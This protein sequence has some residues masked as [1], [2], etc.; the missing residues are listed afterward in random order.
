MR[1]MADRLGSGARAPSEK[2]EYH[3]RPCDLVK[4]PSPWAWLDYV[5][6]CDRNRYGEEARQERQAAGQESA[7]H[8]VT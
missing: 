7:V 6:T 5:T 3:W 2:L 8:S 4:F 1:W